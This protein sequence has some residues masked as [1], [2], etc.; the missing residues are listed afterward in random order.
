MYSLIARA[1]VI[2]VVGVAVLAAGA[3][4]GNAAVLVR[5][6]AAASTAVSLNC[7]AIIPVSASFVSGRTGWLLSDRRCVLAH[8]RRRTYLDGGDGQ[9]PLGQQL[10]RPA[11]T[12]GTG[13][14]GCWCSNYLGL[15]GLYGRSGP[16]LWYGRGGICGH[17]GG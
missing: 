11:G 7:R 14:R 1:P 4:A 12:G 13:Q 17:R 9:P 3:C 6:A 16:R 8:P 10:S 2:V 15:D 5:P